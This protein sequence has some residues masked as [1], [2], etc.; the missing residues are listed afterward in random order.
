MNWK[1]C[2]KCAVLSM[3]H[4]EGWGI[5]RKYHSNALQVVVSVWQ[6][7]IL[8]IRTTCENVCS[9]ADLCR[10]NLCLIWLVFTHGFS[11]ILTLKRGFDLAPFIET[12]V[13]PSWAI[14]WLCEDGCRGTYG[15]GLRPDLFGHWRIRRA[16]THLWRWCLHVKVWSREQ[17]ELGWFLSSRDQ[18]LDEHTLDDWE[19]SICCQCCIQQQQPF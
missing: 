18:T 3:A 5:Y 6:L 11:N 16:S 2:R 8:E 15:K 10:L 19:P 4:R 9:K 7:I 14:L 12:E 13:C 1:R 17:L